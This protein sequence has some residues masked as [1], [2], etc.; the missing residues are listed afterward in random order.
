MFGFSQT[1]CKM[2]PFW[3]EMKLLFTVMLL[4]LAMLFVVLFS[5][6]K[7]KRF[8]NFEYQ[9]NNFML[10]S[11]NGML[12]VNKYMLYLSPEKHVAT[13]EAYGMVYHLLDICKRKLCFCYALMTINT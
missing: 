7:L 8:E 1:V 6:L 2:S 11:W 12:F 13:S 10:R 9:F 5:F 4:A 3:D